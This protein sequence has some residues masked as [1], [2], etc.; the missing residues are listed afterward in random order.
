M[1]RL[2]AEAL[3]FFDQSSIVGNGSGSFNQTNL[4]AWGELA[5][6]PDGVA[7]PHNIFLETAAELGVVGIGLLAAVLTV[8]FFRV[9]L[10]ILSSLTLLTAVIISATIALFSGDI[11]D[12]RMFVICAAI[13]TCL[14]DPRVHA[15]NLRRHRSGERSVVTS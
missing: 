14:P 8:L 9:R 2:W 1:S 5:R 10:R 3:R 15:R 13:A 11:S 4:T 12:H 7:Y 6:G